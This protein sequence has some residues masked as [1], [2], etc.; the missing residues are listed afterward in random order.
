MKTVKFLSI[1]I[2]LL[3]QVI[4]LNAQFSHLEI[5]LDEYNLE[6]YN[7]E[8][9]EDGNFIVASSMLNE[10]NKGAGITLLEIDDNFNIIWTRFYE[11]GFDEIR[12]TDFEYV[13]QNQ[14][15]YVTGYVLKSEIN[16]Q[17]N[18]FVSI[19]DRSLNGDHF[20][21]KLFKTG[22]NSS[23]GLVI[24]F[25]EELDR[26]VVGGFKENGVTPYGLLYVIKK[27]L[28]LESSN[29]YFAD[30][31]RGSSSTPFYCGRYC[32]ISDI[33]LDGTFN[34]NLIIVGTAE[35]EVFYAQIDVSGGVQNIPLGPGGMN[36]FSCFPD[37]SPH[38]SGEFSPSISS[39]TPDN[40]VII[41][42][43]DSKSSTNV[44]F[45][46]YDYSSNST[47]FRVKLNGT[48]NHEVQDLFY[49]ENA[50]IL[51]IHGL[52]TSMYSSSS[53]A[54]Y[55]T[56]QL[57]I[58]NPSNIGSTFNMIRYK[59]DAAGFS[60]IGGNLLS[61]T[62]MVAAEMV[63]NQ[64]VM[65]EMSSSVSQ[66]NIFLAPSLESTNF[67][68]GIN[69]FN[70]N[71]NTP[72]TTECIY[73]DDVETIAQTPIK[74]DRVETNSIVVDDELFYYNEVFLDFYTRT[75][76][77]SDLEFQRKKI[78]LKEEIIYDDA[79]SFEVYSLDGKFLL[80]THSIG[81]IEMNLVNGIYIIREFNN[82]GV[83]IKNRKVFIE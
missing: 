77:Q 34:N 79:S 72:Q 23:L 33:T 39:V 58:S 57:D 30:I 47:I 67:G 62:G 36:N 32:T 64:E 46:Q 4:S 12:I 31:N 25:F 51:R 1:T 60:S 52:R 49:D 41:V 78:T 3:F 22:Q 15:I 24:K 20:K 35:T 13:A 66:F 56:W 18:I 14:G 9:T 11:T 59:D 70:F 5:F 16:D 71:N 50:D 6:D 69:K 8:E 54:G 26:I 38:F 83:N 28:N 65:T 7:I 17:K 61:F 81:Q 75:Q 27:N 43:E 40:S 63:A 73:E 55:H 76:C 80:K 48:E 53:P 42:A 37:F 29:E 10:D 45:Y 82:K 21:S 2:I 74:D 44:N 68:I 19:F